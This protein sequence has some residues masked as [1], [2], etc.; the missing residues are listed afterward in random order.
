MI[1]DRIRLAFLGAMVLGVVMVAAGCTSVPDPVEPT[2]PPQPQA[3]PEPQPPPHQAEVKLEVRRSAPVVNLHVPVT[4]NNPALEEYPLQLEIR[5]EKDGSDETDAVRTLFEQDLLD[6]GLRLAAPGK[7]GHAT[8]QVLVRINLKAWQV[9]DLGAGRVQVHG[10][11]ELAVDRKSDHL[12]L[13]RAPLSAKSGANLTEV[14]ATRQ[15]LDKMC[16]AAADLVHKKVSEYAVLTHV[17]VV[18]LDTESEE[19]DLDTFCDAI[20]DAIR[21]EDGVVL[22]AREQDD[23]AKTAKFILWLA[24]DYQGDLAGLLGKKLEKSGTDN[25][26]EVEVNVNR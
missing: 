21:A 16:S 26:T 11:G 3:E 10:D 7:L 18:S 15:V 13:Y 2:P 23:G 5:A 14:R 22:V 20:E 8:A 17:K 19:I 12:P 9:M 24:P 6:L 25:R 4:T 1:A